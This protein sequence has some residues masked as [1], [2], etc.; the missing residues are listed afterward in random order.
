MK[1]YVCV[2]TGSWRALGSGCFPLKVQVQ[3]PYALG[4]QKLIEIG[5]GCCRLGI[6][7]EVEGY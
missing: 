6:E 5:R 3:V 4:T 2:T 1:S 7:L